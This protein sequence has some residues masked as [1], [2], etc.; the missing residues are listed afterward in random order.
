MIDYRQLYED[1]RREYERLVKDRDEWRQCSENWKQESRRQEDKFRDMLDQ[2]S[3]AWRKIN[4]LCDRF[5]ASRAKLDD[6]AHRYGVLESERNLLA[7]TVVNA[8]LG[9]VKQ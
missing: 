4:D 1:K 5:D 8:A 6:L 7:C 3:E 2:R 9:M